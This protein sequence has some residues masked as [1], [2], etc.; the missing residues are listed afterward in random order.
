MTKNSRLT[1]NYYGPTYPNRTS[2]ASFK[3]DKCCA[4]NGADFKQP[5][6]VNKHGKLIVIED[7][8]FVSEAFLKFMNDALTYNEPHKEV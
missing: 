5:L 3:S 7:D 8:D 2:L 4:I 1:L 6:S